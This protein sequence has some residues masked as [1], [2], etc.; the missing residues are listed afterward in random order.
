[1]AARGADLYRLIEVPNEMVGSVS[2]LMN[3]RKEAP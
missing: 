2:A 1:M 3:G